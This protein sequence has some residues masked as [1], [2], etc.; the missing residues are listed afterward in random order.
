[1]TRGGSACGGWTEPVREVE[2]KATLGLPSAIASPSLR[3]EGAYGTAEVRA[4]CSY[5]SSKCSARAS[6]DAGNGKREP[7]LDIGVASAQGQEEGQARGRQ[8]AKQMVVE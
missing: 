3:K 2:S 5:S 7:V 4:R 8:H 1:M 6:S